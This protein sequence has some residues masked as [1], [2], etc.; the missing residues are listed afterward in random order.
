MT[1]T[2]VF[3]LKF[4]VRKQDDEN[5][6]IGKLL[7]ILHTPPCR[8]LGPTFPFGFESIVC[9]FSPYLWW[10][11][12]ARVFRHAFENDQSPMDGLAAANLYVTIGSSR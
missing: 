4:V 6:W 9:V 11:R 2:M 8:N 1:A 3:F 10:A 12:N 7:Y 5:V